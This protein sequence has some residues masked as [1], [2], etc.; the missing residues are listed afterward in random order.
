MNSERKSGLQN[1]Q[2]PYRGMLC[3]MA[4]EYILPR[5]GAVGDERGVEGSNHAQSNG[6][7]PVGIHQQCAGSD[8][9]LF[10]GTN[11]GRAI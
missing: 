7:R 4:D 3:D 9:L 8:Q 10:R 1:D 6:N 11:A 5:I 2:L